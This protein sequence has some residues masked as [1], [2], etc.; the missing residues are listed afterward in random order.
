MSFAVEAQERIYYALAGNLV[1]QNCFNARAIWAA[2]GTEA[3]TIS[4]PR[5]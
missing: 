2:V 5:T 4:F 1:L 3:G